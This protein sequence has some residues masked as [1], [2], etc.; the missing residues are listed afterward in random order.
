MSQEENQ[1]INTVCTETG[2]W[3]ATVKDLD[4]ANL[5]WYRS[6]RNLGWT[7]CRR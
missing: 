2:R 1:R 6:A 7:V 4:A 3:H 5:Y